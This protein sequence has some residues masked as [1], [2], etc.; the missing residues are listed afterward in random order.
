MI[1]LES[2]WPIIFLGMIAEAILAIMLMRSGRGMLL[3]AM[4][5]VAVVVALGLL[6]ERSVVTDSK[7]VHQTLEEVCA[8][9]ETNDFNRV[10][11]QIT[12]KADGNETRAQDQAVLSMADI[13]EMSLRGVETE[14]NYNTAPPTAKSTFFVMASGHMRQGDMAM[15]DLTRPGK[16]QVTLRK[17]GDNWLIVSH[18][19][20]Q[21]PRD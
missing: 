19:I 18:K 16:I 9:L 10:S 1:F 5:G 17:E 12:S 4:A 21:D 2:P 6:L 14:F 13:K 20:L 11:A 3:L 15:A 7:R 8:G